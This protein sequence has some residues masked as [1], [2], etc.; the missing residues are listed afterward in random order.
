MVTGK[1][2]RWEPRRAVRLARWAVRLRPDD[3]LVANTLGVALFRV[4]ND[5]EDVPL[6]EKCLAQSAGRNDG[7]NLF[8]LAMCRQRLGQTARGS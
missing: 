4:G 5:A 1:P 6:L 8:V 3:R 2:W 7:W